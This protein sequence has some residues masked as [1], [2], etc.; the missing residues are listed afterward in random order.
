MSNILAT[1]GSNSA[2]S[3]NFSLVKY[4][5]RQVTESP[6]KTLELAGYSFP[7]YSEDLEKSAGIPREVTELRLP[8]QQASGLILSVNEHNGNPSA[9]FKNLLDWL[10]RDERS[11]LEGTPVLLMSASGGKRGAISSRNAVEQML[12]RFGAEVVACF[13]LPGYY[14]NFSPEEGITETQLAASHREALNLFL[15]RVTAKS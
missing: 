3:I 15:S 6:V 4:T 8:L 12:N 1:A 14:E 10:S 9:F 11:F 2:T 7:M 13:S 5:A